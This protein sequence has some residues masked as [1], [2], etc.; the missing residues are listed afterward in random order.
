MNARSTIATLGSRWARVRQT[1]DPR[2]A[3]ERA[4]RLVARA[5]HG[6]HSVAELA[7]VAVAAAPTALP[8]DFR[9]ALGLA[10]GAAWLVHGA[11]IEAD[12]Y[13]RRADRTLARDVTANAARALLM[14]ALEYGSTDPSGLLEPRASITLIRLS[15]GERVRPSPFK[16]YEEMIRLGGNIGTLRGHFAGAAGTQM[17][18]LHQDAQRHLLRVLSAL[19]GATAI[20]YELAGTWHSHEGLRSRGSDTAA[21]KLFRKAHVDPLDRVMEAAAK[22]AVASAQQLSAL[23]PATAAPPDVNRAPYAARHAALA[24]AA[25]AAR[26]IVAESPPAN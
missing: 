22:D 7:L 4:V 17:V 18:N 5:Q 20:V 16:A 24:L 26:R 10:A 15:S 1:L 12:H 19:D 3:G 23:A 11:V 8:V 14:Y 2:Q 9:L 25:A 21:L 13:V 6:P